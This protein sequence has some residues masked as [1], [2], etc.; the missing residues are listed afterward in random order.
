MKWLLISLCLAVIAC[1]TCI[2]VAAS[3][4]RGVLD[5]GRGLW[6]DPWFVATLMDAYFGFLTFFVWVA[7]KE[8]SWVIRGTWFVAIMLLGN[9]VMSGYVLWQLS[10]MKNFSWEALLLRPQTAV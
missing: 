3:L 2:T 1:M 7:Y 4:D 6:P 5:A 10:K 9:F 8:Q